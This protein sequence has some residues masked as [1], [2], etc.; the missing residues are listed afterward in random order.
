MRISLLLLIAVGFGCGAKAGGESVHPRGKEFSS[1]EESLL[2]EV[3][4]SPLN[5]DMLD[6]VLVDG[7]LIAASSSDYSAVAQDIGLGWD[8]YWGTKLAPVSREE[9][10]SRAS[11]F[12]SRKSLSS[13]TAFESAGVQ[14]LRRDPE[15]IADRHPART[16]VMHYS[17]PVIIDEGSSAY[18]FVMLSPI[19]SFVD[20]EGGQNLFLYKA[21]PASG[22]WAI[23]DVFTVSV[24]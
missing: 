23:S 11:E 24:S 4:R 3:L 13:S 18:I 1:I 10:V 2:L 19:Q 15:D 9:W 14:I 12:G 20:W 8:R 17:T 7:C 5:S 6:A 21:I 22:G 16:I